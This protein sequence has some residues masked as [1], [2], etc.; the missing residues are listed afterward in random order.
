MVRESDSVNAPRRCRSMRLSRYDYSQAGTYF[1]TICTQG[2]VCVLGDVVD[3]QV[4][5]SEFGRLAHSVWSE[6]PRHYP[7]VR[8]DAWV[9]MP[10][11]VHGI[12]MLEPS[13]DV[14]RAGLKPAPTCP[15]T[16]RVA[17]G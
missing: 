11:H 3:G 1:V 17:R 5:L 12:V 15:R 7:H 8:L 13:D 14:V 6:L 4:R 16:W 10:N 9:D 2:S